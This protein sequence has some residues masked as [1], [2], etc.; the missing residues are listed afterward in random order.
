MQLADGYLHTLV[1]GVEVYTDGQPTG[2][3]PGRLIRGAK[4]DP[5]G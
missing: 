2:E 3:L 5:V 1:S 4:A